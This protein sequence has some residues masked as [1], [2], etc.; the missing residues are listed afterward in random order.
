MTRSWT[1]V[2][3]ALW[4]VATV[5][6]G[7]SPSAPTRNETAVLRLTFPDPVVAAPSSDPR[8]ALEATVPMVITETSG[9]GGAC[10]SYFQVGI[11]DAATGVAA[12]PRPIVTFADPR[13]RIGSQ[14][15]APLCFGAGKSV[16][17]PFRVSLP[18]TG[19]FR[20]VVT[21]TAWT[22]IPNSMYNEYTNFIGEFRI[23]PPQ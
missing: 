1:L 4:A 19:T 11:D 3:V 22:A 15:P 23:V 12:S 10:I 8:F 17:A 16:E 18:S 2:A 14:P 20:V 5:G 7:N 13:F 21:L 9:D 6:C